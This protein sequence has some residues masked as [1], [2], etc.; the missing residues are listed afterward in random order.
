LFRGKFSCVLEL[1][2]PHLLFAGEPVE[3]VSFSARYS[4]SRIRQT[5][6]NFNSEIG[7]A[8]SFYHELITAS[9][10]FDH[11]RRFMPSFDCR[12]AVSV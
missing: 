8:S 1:S 4:G 7:G 10:R 2:S 11:G 3:I 12:P 9:L 5:P 6:G